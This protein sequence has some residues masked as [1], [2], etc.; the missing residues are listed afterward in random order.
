MPDS[1]T[2]PSTLLTGQIVYNL[3]DYRNDYNY[4]STGNTSITSIVYSDSPRLDAPCFS[5]DGNSSTKIN[6]YQELLG[7]DSP[8]SVSKIYKL[9]IQAPPGTRVILNNDKNIMIG[10]TSVYELDDN[11][12]IE[13]MRFVRP[14][15]YVL[16][17]NTTDSKLQEGI[18]GLSL[19]KS[20]FEYAVSQITQE[21]GTADYW[22]QYNQCYLDY[23]RE[24]QNAY[25]TFLQGVNGVYTQPNPN[26]EDADENFDELTD[27]IIDFLYV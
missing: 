12:T 19:A 13:N 24:Y 4:I 23:Q 26:E 25:A 17:E 16:D 11:F 7:E 18:E 14:K 27:V 5:I 1:S 8:I 10:R 15:K 20:N 21:P 2:R 6:I 9:G 22:K 3:R